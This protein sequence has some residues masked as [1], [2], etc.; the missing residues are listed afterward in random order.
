MRMARGAADR[1]GFSVDQCIRQDAGLGIQVLVFQCLPENLRPVV[2]FFLPGKVVLQLFQDLLPGHVGV[3]S[4]LK[5]VQ[6][7]APLFGRVPRMGPFGPFFRGGEQ[8]RIAALREHVQ[9]HRKVRVSE[10][11]VHAHEL[12]VLRRALAG[13]VVVLCREV[14]HACLVCRTIDGIDA[15]ILAGTRL[16]PPDFVLRIGI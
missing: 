11:R 10:E 5:S 9:D 13:N 3:Q 4:C 1:T 7:F 6:R 8:V 15:N 12:V 2:C 16:N 14:T